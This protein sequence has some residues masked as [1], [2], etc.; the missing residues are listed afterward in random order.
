MRTCNV[1]NSIM[2]PAESARLP[3][4]QGLLIR[5]CTSPPRNLLGQRRR[6][7]TTTSVAA[8]PKDIDA[9]RLSIPGRFEGGPPP[10][11][12]GI[13]AK[14]NLAGMGK[15]EAGGRLKAK[16]KVKRTSLPDADV[17]GPLKVNGQAKRTSL[18]MASMKRT[19]LADVV[20]KAK[21]ESTA[22]PRRTSIH[23]L[24]A[25]QKT[26]EEEEEEEEVKALQR[27]IEKL[28]K[29]LER[30]ER[31]EQKEIAA[32]EKDTARRK[33]KQWRNF[34]GDPDRQSEKDKA[35]Q[36]IKYMERG[37]V[38]ANNQK[39]IKEL[40]EDNNKVR[41]HM[42][43]MVVESA[44]IEEQNESLHRENVALRVQCL[45]YA[46]LFKDREKTFFHVADR[47]PEYRHNIEVYRTAVEKR[48]EAVMMEQ[49]MKKNCD[50]QT[51]RIMGNIRKECDDKNLVREI[52]EYLGENL[53]LERRQSERRLSASDRRKS[54]RRLSVHEPKSRVS[55]G[56][57]NRRASA[58][59]LSALRS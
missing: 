26:R 25:E 8:S 31:E 11:L 30:T 7:A 21:R 23:K 5:D 58:P 18:K 36:A 53:E 24:Q 49:D 9:K 51:A 48:D 54:E 1:N 47:L 45:K 17:G 27:K 52:Y 50:L 19:S 35:L 38:L 20:A 4:S 12:T 16:A 32:I 46:E 13:A 15:S 41:K 3:Q 33:K 34:G 59:N 40:R 57:R 14:L 42:K 55:K 29:K 39:I 43:N 44:I 2:G 56:P 6:R 22:R 10:P 28:Q 37:E